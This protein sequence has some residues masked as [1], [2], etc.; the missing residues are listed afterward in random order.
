MISRTITLT[1][2]TF[3]AG[4][5]VTTKVAHTMGTE[6]A[7]ATSCPVFVHAILHGE[8]MRARRRLCDPVYT[9]LLGPRLRLARSSV[10][11][12]K[13]AAE[14]S[15]R[16]ASDVAVVFAVRLSRLGLHQHTGPHLSA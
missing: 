13:A 1:R 12:Y 15:V 9:S 4:Y 2:N 11:A 6:H 16:A 8:W 3:Y 7:L 5:L 10:P 14:S